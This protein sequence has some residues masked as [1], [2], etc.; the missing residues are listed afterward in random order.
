MEKEVLEVLI[1]QE[2]EAISLFLNR[3]RC[4]G[5]PGLQ[6]ILEKGCA[7]HKNHLK[8]LIALSEGEEAAAPQNCGEITPLQMQNR[9]ILSYA[10]SL[11]EVRQEQIRAA[12]V[13]LL[14]DELTLQGELLKTTV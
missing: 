4:M 12:L 5:D 7:K 1:C 3:A 2:E 14:N 13:T 8:K 9:L 10:A 6:V 11:C